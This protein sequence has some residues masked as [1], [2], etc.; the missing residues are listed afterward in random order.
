MAFE[1]PWL[2]NEATRRQGSVDHFGEFW[3]PL[4]ISATAEARNSKLDMQNDRE[5]PSRKQMTT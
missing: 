3:D 5:V 1:T 4:H 2:R